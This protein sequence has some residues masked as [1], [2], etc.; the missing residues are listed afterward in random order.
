M[1]FAVYPHH[2]KPEMT[3]DMCTS[4]AIFGHKGLILYGDFYLFDRIIHPHFVGA[5]GDVK[6]WSVL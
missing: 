5:V 3:Y 4:S 6:S 1:L 2:L